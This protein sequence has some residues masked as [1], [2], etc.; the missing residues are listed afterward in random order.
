[1]ATKV[2][3]ELVDA[4]YGK[5]I[6]LNIHP[7]S[8]YMGALGAAMFALEDHRAGQVGPLPDFVTKARSEIRS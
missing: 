2:L 5:D 3:R 8:I 4:N 7:D 1:M 6:V